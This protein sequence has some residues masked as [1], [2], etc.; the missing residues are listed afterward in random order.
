MLI[1]N[2]YFQNSIGLSSAMQNKKTLADIDAKR[3]M[4]TLRI[5]IALIYAQLV[6]DNSDLYQYFLREYKFLNAHLINPF[7]SFRHLHSSSLPGQHVLCQLR[8]YRGGQVLHAQVLRQ[9]LLSIV[10]RGRPVAGER[11]PYRQL[12]KKKKEIRS[13]I[14]R[15]RYQ[16]DSSV[17]PTHT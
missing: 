6:S 2:F 12:E 4:N 16:I 1:T 7:I 9:V 10:H 17:F 15:L 8:T 13:S 5:P 14:A 3:P 11:T